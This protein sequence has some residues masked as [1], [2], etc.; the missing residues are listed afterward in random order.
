[1]FEESKPLGE[2]G[3]YWLKV[4]LLRYYIGVLMRGVSMGILGYNV[5]ITP[6]SNRH[7][8]GLDALHSDTESVQ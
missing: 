5:A 4:R 6:P 1:M 7:P 2:R 8:C 3:L